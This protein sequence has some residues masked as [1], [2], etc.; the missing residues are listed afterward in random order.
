MLRN[1]LVQASGADISRRACV[2]LYKREIP[3]L[4]TVYD[5]FL[6]KIEL[7]K[8]EEQIKQVEDALSVASSQ[9][10]DGFS[11]KTNI[12]LIIK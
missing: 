3:L 11:L 4:L 1:W 9:V 2:E 5:A 10:L 12:E 6:V 8:Y 7:S